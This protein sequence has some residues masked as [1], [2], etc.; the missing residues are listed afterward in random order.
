MIDIVK[1]L[2]KGADYE[3]DTEVMEQA[4][5]EITRLRAALR[6]IALFNDDDC[7]L[8]VRDMQSI[9]RAALKQE[10]GNG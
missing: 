4:A 10:D 8:S 9:A 2:R 1:M 7:V 3:Y 6:E 5:D